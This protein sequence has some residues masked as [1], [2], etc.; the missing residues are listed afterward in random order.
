AQS[1][2]VSLNAAGQASFSIASL[3]LGPHQIRAT[4]NGD[5]N[6]QASTSGS[7]TQTV[8]RAGT[9]T[10]VTASANASSRGQVV[11]FTA[12]VVSAVDPSTGPPTGTVTFLID[13][14]A[15]VL[16]GNLVSGQAAFTTDTLGAGSHTILARYN[17]DTNFQ[18]STS[19]GWTQ[20]VKA[21]SST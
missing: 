9:A 16:D 5:A 12:Q 8:D 13:G 14:V 1:P 19:A 2:N 15:Q 4:Y 20:T 11:T 18:P 3:A 21:G 17:G 10:T 7:L 6:F